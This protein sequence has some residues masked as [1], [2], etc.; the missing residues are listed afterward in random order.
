NIQ[1]KSHPAGDSLKVP[2][3]GHRSRQGNMPH[4][5]AAYAGLC[6][7]NTAPVTHNTFIADLLVL[8]AMAFPV[9]ARSKYLFAEKSVLFRF[10]RTVINCF[11]FC[12]FASGPFQDLLR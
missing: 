11:R 7:F 9:L 12:H 2:D 1:N 4:T 6:Y 10:Q 5:L 8:S 3:M